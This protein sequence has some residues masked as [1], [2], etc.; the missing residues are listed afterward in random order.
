MKIIIN[1]ILPFLTIFRIYIFYNFFSF[2]NVFFLIFYNIQFVL[3][4]VTLLQKKEIFNTIK[5]SLHINETLRT[6]LKIKN[7]KLKIKQKV[8]VKQSN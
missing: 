6:T 2:S 4:L 3:N 5:Y 8:K 7:K 1:L